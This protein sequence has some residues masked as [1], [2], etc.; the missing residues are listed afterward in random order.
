MM[1]VAAQ[2]KELVPRAYVVDVVARVLNQVRVGVMSV[3]DRLYR[4]KGGFPAEMTMKW[5]TEA[6][7]TCRAALD[8]AQKAVEKAMRDLADPDDDGDAADV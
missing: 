5:R 7:D 1:K 2:A 8:Q 6:T 4:E 3:P